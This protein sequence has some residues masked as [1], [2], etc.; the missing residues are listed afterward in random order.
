[1]SEQV[2]QD[3]AQENIEVSIVNE[4]EQ[5]QSRARSNS[6]AAIEEARK[7]RKRAQA[8]EKSLEELKA[9]LAERD[10]L[11]A[12]HQQTIASLERRQAIDEQLRLADVID[13]ESA[14][15]LTELAVNAMND[16]DV[17]AAVEDLRRTNPALFRTRQRRASVSAPKNGHEGSARI[18]ALEH[19]ALEASTTGKRSDLLRYLRLR[20]R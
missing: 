16:A 6:A 3:Q 10:N 5:D 14:R 18:D 2:A 19:A 13:F 12:E 20:R 15:L 7:Y 4:V 1:M 9:Q 11:I 17:S 8:A